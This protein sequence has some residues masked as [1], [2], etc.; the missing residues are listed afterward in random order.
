MQI[1]IFDS[2]GVEHITKKIKKFIE[3]KNMITNIYRI[4][5]YDIRK[6]IFACLFSIHNTISLSCHDQVCLSKLRFERYFSHH[7]GMWM[8]MSHIFK[9]NM[10][11]KLDKSK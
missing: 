10:R 5:A 3:N 9:G 6:N 4:Q 11:T 7:Q 1:N 8:I 2:F